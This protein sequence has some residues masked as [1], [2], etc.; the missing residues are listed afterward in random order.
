[1]SPPPGQFFK[2]K[3]PEQPRPPPSTSTN[4]DMR[5]DSPSPSTDLITKEKTQPT[6]QSP[7]YDPKAKAP[8]KR[9]ITKPSWLLSSSL[10]NHVPRS[11]GTSHSP[12]K[13]YASVSSSPG[14][15]RETCAAT[16]AS[17]PQATVRGTLYSGPSGL[18]K[19]FYKATIAGPVSAPGS[20]SDTL[21]QRKDRPEKGS[22]AI[23]AELPNNIVSSTRASLSSN[24]PGGIKPAQST[25]VGPDLLG[26]S[27]NSTTRNDKSKSS[28]FPTGELLKLV[29]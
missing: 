28:V 1:M 3:T 21:P 8:D 12:T 15:Q 23:R 25:A 7:E 2:A 27:E 29:F 26:S 19:N 5:V 11:S 10:V 13:A 18:W 16:S 22:K 4:S 14:R 9:P 24:K 20:P 6:P 17:P